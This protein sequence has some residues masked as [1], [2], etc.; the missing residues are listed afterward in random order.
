MSKTK[1]FKRVGGASADVLQVTVYS[2]DL[3][4]SSGQV[5][6][7]GAVKLVITNRITDIKK[8]KIFKGEM[9]H[10]DGERWLN[11]VIGYP[12]PFAGILTLGKFMTE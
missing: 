2:G 6:E 7:N 4:D 10:W 8:S 1:N 12:N 11:D 3:I 9:A 5:W